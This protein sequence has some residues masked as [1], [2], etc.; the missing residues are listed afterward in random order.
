[1]NNSENTRKAYF[2]SGC[3]WG[4]EYWFMKINGV[5]RTSVGFM[6]GNVDNPTYPQVKTGTTGHLECVEVEY[7]PTKTTYENLLTLFFETHNFTQTDG[8]GPD[9][10]SQYLSCLFYTGETEKAAAENCIRRLEKMGYRVATQLQP[11]STFW[12]AEDYHQQYY[13]H[14]GTQPYCHIYRKIF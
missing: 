1:M 12:I 8:Q 6:G 14:K 3:F 5:K 9:I 4:T 11:A 2:A 10:G 13:E 7:D